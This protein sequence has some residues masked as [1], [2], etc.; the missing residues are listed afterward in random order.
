MIYGLYLSATGVLTNSHRQD[1]IANNLANAET[2]G[3]KRS[4][5]LFQQRRTEAQDSG[6]F[7]ETNSTLDKI[8]GGLLLAPTAVDQTQG[9][10]EPSGNNLDVAILGSGYFTVQS[11]DQTRLTRDGQFMTD[12]A[13]W[14]T[15]ADGSG[16]RVLDE[17]GKPIAIKDV[18]SSQVSID[19]DGTITAAGQAVARIG[20]VDVPDKTQLV[21]QGGT[22]M[23]YPDMKQLTAAS[24]TMQSGFIERS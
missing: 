12:R 18:P 22:L 23:S 6:K 19:K 10:P 3:F 20:M 15:L 17:K 9:T 13:G 16:N 8:G 4:L 2:V 5:A 1:V 7:G 14:L 21:Q 24:G 11:G